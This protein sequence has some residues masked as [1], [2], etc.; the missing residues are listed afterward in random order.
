MAVNPPFID[1]DDADKIAKGW[2]DNVA[3]VILHAWSNNAYRT[4]LLT[5]PLQKGETEAQARERTKKQ[6][7]DRGIDISRPVVL[8]QAEF[9][10]YA[11]KAEEVVLILPEPFGKGTSLNDAKHAMVFHCAGV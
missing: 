5:Y 11:P 1:P 9:L 4:N 2:P 7:S 8:T 10:A 6:L 3:D